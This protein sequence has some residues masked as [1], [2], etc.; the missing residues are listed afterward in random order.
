[1][2]DLGPIHQLGIDVLD[3]LFLHELDLSAFHESGV[4]AASCAGND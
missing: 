3:L 4:H 1:V 2:K